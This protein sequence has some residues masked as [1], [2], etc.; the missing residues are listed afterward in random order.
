LFGGVYLFANFIE[1]ELNFDTKTVQLLVAATLLNFLSVKYTLLPQSDIIFFGLSFFVLYLVHIQASSVAWRVALL[2]SAALFCYIAIQVR[3]FGIV[4]LPVLV[5]S[6]IRLFYPTNIAFIFINTKLVRYFVLACIFFGIL[7]ITA[8][9]S[10][11][12]GSFNL[13]FLSSP[14]EFWTHISHKLASFGQITLNIPDSIGDAIVIPL[15]IA[16]MII[17]L[18]TMFGFCSRLSNLQLMD[19]YAIISLGII[20]LWP[21]YQPRFWVPLIPV[22]FTYL[23]MGITTL[24]HWRCIRIIATTAGIGYV[25]LGLIAL[26]HSTWLTFSDK[27]FAERYGQSS[28]RKIYQAAFNITP[29]HNL[30]GLEGSMF[31][32]LKTYEPLANDSNR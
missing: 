2:T 12:W 13:K 4:L 25:V 7:L 11:Y 23:F 9:K 28:V 1:K 6:F 18:I 8:T 17:A 14:T 3:T 31:K 32:L 10:Q 26:G 20:F 16:G 30:I 27:K 24:W 5:L 21:Y 22:I 19:L 15:A 29:S